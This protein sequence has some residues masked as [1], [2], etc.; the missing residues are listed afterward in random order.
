M[1][2]SKYFF[3]YEVG[4]SNTANIQ[5]IL[6]EPTKE[7]M[8]AAQLL[9]INV[10]DPIREHFGT[11]FSP[12]SWYRSEELER[13]IT[14]KAFEQWCRNRGSPV[15]QFSWI[16]Y[17][18]K[19]SHPRGEAVD[20]SIPGVD[21]IDL[22]NWIKDN[23]IYDQLILESTWVHVSFSATYNRKEAFEIK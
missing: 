14:K 19:K 20:I 18:N 3:D 13:F 15:S 23:I 22:F 6:N 1:K 2:L 7:V 16:E 10:L 12:Q 21:R 9:A 17:F 5:E 8:V 11:P 4:K